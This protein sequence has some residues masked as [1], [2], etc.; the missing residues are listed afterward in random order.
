M[1]VW[2]LESLI[3]LRFLGYNTGSD[4]VGL[5]L[6]LGICFSDN[7]P[8][9]IDTIG[10][11]SHMLRTT[12]FGNSDTEGHHLIDSKDIFGGVDT[13]NSNTTFLLYDLVLLWFLS[14]QWRAGVSASYSNLQWNSPSS[15]KKQK[16]FSDSNSNFHHDAQVDIPESTQ[17]L[18]LIVKFNTLHH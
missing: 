4:S 3:K 18:G 14:F 1:N 16:R 12:A 10:L 7:F 8:G 5:G 9:D 17:I 2:D 11:G 6:S 15:Y 13:G